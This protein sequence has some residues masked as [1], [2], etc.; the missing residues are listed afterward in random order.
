M[1]PVHGAP[2]AAHFDLAPT[3]KGWGKKALLTVVMWCLPHHVLHRVPADQ[4]SRQC[5][6]IQEDSRASPPLAVMPFMSLV[7]SRAAYPYVPVVVPA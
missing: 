6:P 7:H 4:L 1:L 2:Q 3:K 5:S